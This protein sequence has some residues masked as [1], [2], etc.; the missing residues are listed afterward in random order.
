MWQ[1]SFKIDLTHFIPT[2]ILV[3]MFLAMIDMLVP[4][5]TRRSSFK[6]RCVTSIYGNAKITLEELY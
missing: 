6:S 4:I 3:I 5:S 1:W 2:T